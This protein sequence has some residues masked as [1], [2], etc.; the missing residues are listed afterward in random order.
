MTAVA[1]SLRGDVVALYVDPR[2]PYPGIVRDWYDAE[3]NAM[4]YRGSLPVVAH[5]PCGPWSHLSQLHKNAEEIALAPHAVAVVQRCGGVLEHPRGSTLFRAC[6]L[7]KPGDGVDEYGGETFEVSQCDWGHPARKR[8]WLYIVGL[9][10]PLPP[11]PGPREPTHW[12]S[13]G[14]TRSSRHG[15]PVP[16][17]IK[18]CSAQ[19]RR[20][21]PPDF[22]RWLVELA[23]RC[24]DQCR[25][26]ATPNREGST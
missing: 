15:S 22:A 4:T 16:P 12:A 8:T 10:R 25:H 7:P 11:K 2:G 20:R 5:P 1:P 21:T 3:R 13:G 9:Q 6:Y 14:R 24:T 17:G 18:V 26:S 23:S 19:Q